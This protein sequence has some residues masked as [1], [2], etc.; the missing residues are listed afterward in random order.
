MPPSGG[1]FSVPTKDL[2]DLEDS[3][4]IQEEKT[5]FFPY[6]SMS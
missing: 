1:P 6:E 2:E 3:I 5:A 4:Q